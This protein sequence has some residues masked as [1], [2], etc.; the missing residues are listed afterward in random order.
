MQLFS[1]TK[2]IFIIEDSTAIHYHFKKN[3]F[4]AKGTLLQSDVL[5]GNVSLKNIPN[6]VVMVNDSA[7]TITKGT[8]P[9]VSRRNRDALIR[10]TLNS[11]Y[12]AQSPLGYHYEKTTSDEM[13]YNAYLLSSPTVLQW[14]SCLNQNGVLIQGCYALPF[15]LCNWI[16]KIYPTPSNTKTLFFF[17]HNEHLNIMG[18]YGKSVIFSRRLKI[19]SPAFSTDLEE[20]LFFIKR[21]ENKH[22]APFHILIQA[23][24][25]KSNI[26]KIIEYVGLPSTTEAHFNVDV[27]AQFIE[28]ALYRITKNGNLGPKASD[29]EGLMCTF[30]YKLSRFAT[31]LRQLTLITSSVLSG[32]FAYSAWSMSRDC[33]Q[34]QVTLEELTQQH[35]SS[36]F[37][38]DLIRLSTLIK[39]PLTD[40]EK[41]SN[42][43]IQ[44]TFILESLEWKN[45]E[46][47]ISPLDP[48]IILE[49]HMLS[50]E[51][52]TLDAMIS[53]L[54]SSFDLNSIRYRI[55]EDAAE[56]SPHIFGQWLSS[57]HEKKLS[58]PTHE[59]VA[60]EIR[61]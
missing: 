32:L 10:N 49:G 11:T 36:T 20:T 12:D 56:Q 51:R 27:S 39:D 41:I 3:Q 19:A 22:D 30:R 55:L 42:A 53:T 52:G 24:N 48:F 26:A 2:N 17:E 37:D 58:K 29:A 38:D 8:L 23:E 7:M 1:R 18:F 14:L 4:Y 16:G 61:L 28:K 9:L 25:I 31:T 34:Q 15:A 60:I 47:L 33:K 45:P 6:C 44:N 46:F 59:E 35:N 50:N 21:N 57:L 54:K 40:F 43:N 13:S 5:A